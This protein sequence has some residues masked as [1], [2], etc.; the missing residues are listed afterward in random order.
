MSNKIAFLIS[1]SPRTFVIDEM[2]E[3]YKYLIQLYNSKN[4]NIDFYII[5]K[6]DEII[7]SEKTPHH[8]FY[9]EFNIPIINFF[10]TQ[11][12]L[13]NFNKLLELLQPKSIIIFNKFSLSNKMQYSQ[14]KSI[15]II[16]NKAIEYSKNNNF[17]YD[18]FIRTR[19]DLMIMDFPNFY[20]CDKSIFY[21]SNKCDSKINDGFFIFSKELLNIWTNN[22]IYNI[23][24][25]FDS[26]NNF[27]EGTLFKTINTKQI[28]KSI[29]IRNYD[30]VQA[31]NKNP[32]E[33][34]SISLFQNLQN[35]HKI[36]ID[37]I[38]N[39]KEFIKK[40]NKILL[41][42]NTNYQEIYIT[43]S[44]SNNID[45]ID[46]IDSKLP[47]NS[48]VFI[49]GLNNNDYNGHQ[50]III[51]PINNNRYPIKLYN[52][53]EILIKENNITLMVLYNN[54]ENNINNQNQ[55]TYTN[56]Y[57][58]IY[59]II[60]INLILINLSIIYLLYKNLKLNYIFK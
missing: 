28:C 25:N 16:L 27:P 35:P 50:G 22:I 48:K 51:G 2:I 12:G 58:I 11:K 33:K 8:R 21:S 34:V 7:T 6:L 4:I 3:Y 41:P 13:D 9:N 18:Y 55:I 43:K 5:L 45:N 59:F 26:D 56:F 23:E 31:W 46:N 60:I 24:N 39:N 40:L 14:F 37:T 57:Y 15:D 47:I 54:S 19:P 42:Y 44:I 49:H 38:L 29:L 20:S 52:G 10:N 32:E 17:Q 53:K 36:Y 30:L 1:G